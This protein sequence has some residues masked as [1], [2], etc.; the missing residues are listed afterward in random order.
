MR[1]IKRKI[2]DSLVWTAFRL[3][4]INLLP[5]VVIRN[6]IQR[7]TTTNFTLQFK[8]VADQ[9]FW[10]TPNPRPETIRPHYRTATLCKF[11][12]SASIAANL[13]NNESSL[14]DSPHVLQRT[15]SIASCGEIRLRY[16]AVVDAA[17]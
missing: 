6:M 7:I 13:A 2:R 9:P 12:N 5:M 11:R 4:R 10:I 15:A 17:E 3:K 1:S 14:G 16:V 8:N